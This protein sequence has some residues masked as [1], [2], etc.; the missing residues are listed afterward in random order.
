M[1]AILERSVG[2][3][4]GC[5]C[6]EREHCSRNPLH[7]AAS[8]EKFPG[9]AMGLAEGGIGEGRASCKACTSVV[10]V[11]DCGSM[12]LGAPGHLFVR[13]KGASLL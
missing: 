3:S 11:S 2:K 9:R 5:I 6:R 4:W 10:K 8:P 12:I 1:K 7:A 13:K